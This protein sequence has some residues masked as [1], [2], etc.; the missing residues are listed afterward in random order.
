[1][2]YKPKGN[3]VRPI[4]FKESNRIL[5]KPESITDKECE[6]L[7]VFNDGEISV[8]CWQL[9]WKERLQV[10]WYG[11]AWLLVWG[12]YTQPPVCIRA[13]KDEAIIS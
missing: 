8:S 12:G 10:L 4:K 1:M 7:H 9:S 3:V 13:S 2:S 6:S 5:T 11:V